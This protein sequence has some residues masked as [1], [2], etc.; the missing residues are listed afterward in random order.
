[1]NDIQMLTSDAVTLFESAI[2]TA[3]QLSLAEPCNLSSG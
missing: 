1:M 2:N 3:L